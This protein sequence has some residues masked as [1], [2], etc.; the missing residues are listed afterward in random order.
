MHGEKRHAD[1]LPEVD[2]FILLL[3]KRYEQHCH[4]DKANHLTDGFNRRHVSEIYGCPVYYIH[5][6]IS[7][8]KT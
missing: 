7:S 5:V 1:D 6:F 4:S 2:L 3:L 8:L